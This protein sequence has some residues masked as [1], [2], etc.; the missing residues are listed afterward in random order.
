MKLVEALDPFKIRAHVPHFEA[1]VVDYRASSVATRARLRARLNVAFGDHADEK[2]DLFYPEM[3]TSSPPPPIHLFIHGGYW[4]SFSK[5]DYSYVADAIV[6]QGAIAAIPDYSL[7]PSARMARLVDQVRRAANW[8]GR[9]AREFGGDPRA[10]SASGH[11]A[12]GHLASYLICRAPHE[13]EFPDSSIRS[14]LA[15]SGIY[16]LAPIAESFLQPEIH[17]AADEI[18]Q[19][20]PCGATPRAGSR[21]HLAVGGSETAPFFEHANRFADHLAAFGPQLRPTIL[22]G[23]DHMTIVRALGRPDSACAPLLAA[24]IAASRD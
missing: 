16:D 21:L 12:G 23:E 7:M 6:T 9:N 3:M 10:I 14:V 8:L 24:T 13:T 1:C 11:S 4:R 5:D 15:V 2:L 17:L 19:W 18:A 20:S 22:A